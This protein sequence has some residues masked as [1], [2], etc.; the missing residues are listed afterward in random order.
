MSDSP[1]VSLHPVVDTLLLGMF[2]DEIKS[3]VPHLVNTAAGSAI[4]NATPLVDITEDLIEF[5]RVE[6]GLDV[7]MKD[8][9]VYGKLESSMPGGS[10]KVRPAVQIIEEAIASGRLRRHSTVFEATSGNFGI[11]LGLLRKLD[12]EVV[13][14]V[15]RRLQEGV[16]EE[17]EKVGVRTLNLGIDICPAPGSGE[18]A[19]TMVARA[20]A[21]SLAKQLSQIGFDV[22]AL[23]GSRAL[24]EGLLATGDAIKLAKV[25]ANIYG[26]FCPEQYDNESSVRV[27]EVVTGPEIEQQLRVMGGSLADFDV[28]CAFG[29]GGTSAGISRYAR[30]KFGRKAVHVIFPFENQDVAGIRTRATARGLKFFDPDIYAGL[31][32]VDFSAARS[33]VRFFAK[34]GY[35]IGES[36]ALALYETL[37]MIE[38]GVRNRFVVILADGVQKYIAHDE[39]VTSRDGDMEVGVDEAISEMADFGGVLWT[40]PVFSPNERGRELISSS[41][42]YQGRITVVEGGAVEALYTRQAMTQGFNSLVPSDGRKLLLVCM[43]G[44]TSARLVR[45]LSKSGIRAVSLAGGMAALATTAGEEPSELIELA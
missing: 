23:E 8:F 33:A 30:E 28:V 38:I 16:L 36:S 44:S 10:V 4:L 5:G 43:N 18:A 6:C 27:H 41:L 42:G 24:I 15:S 20:R 31:H 21:S 7:S 17:L 12:V 26:G 29:T 34:R 11:A 2:K 37:K 1:E 22:D 19:S 14:L 39:I 13:A 25:L 40:H 3:R 32:D 9:K 45:I 35:D